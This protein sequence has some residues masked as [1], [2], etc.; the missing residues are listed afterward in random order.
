[1]RFVPVTWVREPLLM[2]PREPLSVIQY[3]LHEIQ[4]QC[5]YL[6]VLDNLN[7]KPHNG[8][9]QCTLVAQYTTDYNWNWYLYISSFV[10]NFHAFMVYHISPLCHGAW[11][12]IIINLLK[13][14]ANAI[15]YNILIC[16]QILLLILWY[17]HLT[18]CKQHLKKS[19]HRDDFMQVLREVNWN[20]MEDKSQP[21]RH[22]HNNSCQPL[23]ELGNLHT[24]HII[25][26]TNALKTQTQYLFNI[27]INT[28][29]SI[30]P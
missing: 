21:H 9:C 15:L 29:I 13:F 26:S 1:M 2:H 4:Q 30:N 7:L 12:K 16:T 28:I 10:G 11:H 5:L 20:K 8:L 17:T 23:K 27:I 22:E 25:W 18:K 24:F 6:P 3:T 14:Q 19:Y